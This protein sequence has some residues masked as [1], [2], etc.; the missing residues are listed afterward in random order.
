MLTR[1]SA[2][3][4]FSI[5]N[6]I[7]GDATSSYAMPTITSISLSVSSIGSEAM[8][9]TIPAWVIVVV[10]SFSILNRIGGDATQFCLTDCLC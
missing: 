7:G 3:A 2:P 8:Q 1:R 4:S 9:H 6:R 10:F 5:L